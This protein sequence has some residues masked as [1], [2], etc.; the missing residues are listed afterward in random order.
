MERRIRRDELQLDARRLHRPAEH[1]EHARIGVGAH[2]AQHLADLLVMLGVHLQHM[3]CELPRL[4]LV[5]VLDLHAEG[6]Q[7][8]R[9]LLHCRR[10]RL[11]RGHARVRAARRERRRNVVT[12]LPYGTVPCAAEFNKIRTKSDEG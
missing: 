5:I 8:G 12:G 7:G 6:A 9:S 4:A 11:E 1:E 2:H 3:L 10:E